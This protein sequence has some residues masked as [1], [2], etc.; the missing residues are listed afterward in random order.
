MSLGIYISLGIVGIGIF[1]YIVR[2]AMKGGKKKSMARKIR[3]EEIEQ[4][5]TG[6]EIQELQGRLEM[7]QA[8]QQQAAVSTPA[9]VTAN[10]EPVNQKSGNK[11]SPQ[12]I[13]DMA[14]GHLMRASELLNLLRNLS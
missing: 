5:T 10:P 6:D 8:Q 13:I 4:D 14:N 9:P 1:G 11:V 12:E 3:E 2:R 7:L